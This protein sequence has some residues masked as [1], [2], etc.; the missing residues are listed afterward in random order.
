MKIIYTADSHIYYGDQR[1]A[2]KDLMTA[3]RK[4]HPDVVCNCGDIGE[5][6]IG[7]DMDLVQ[8]LFS[9]QPTLFVP[10]NHDLYSQQKYAPPEAMERFLRNMSYGIPLQKSW[11]DTTTIYEK[12]GVLFLGSILF[13]DFA[14]PRLVMGSKYLDAGCCTID[15]TYINLRGGW[16]QH[17]R[18][19][20]DAFKKKLQLVDESKCKNV[21]IITHYCCFLSQY[22]LNPNEDISAYFYCHQAGEMIKEV[23]NRNADK[24]FYAVGAHGH[25]YNRGEWV[26]DGN[27]FTH[28]IK[29]TYTSQDYISLEIPSITD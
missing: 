15:G 4:E 18:P 6:L 25:E 26:Q 5:I 7:E 2:V 23:A 14:D 12:N 19:L 21:V 27:L 1:K 28:G 3:I 11:T 22:N 8:E 17:T 24:K 20:L 9:I 16:L 10:G 13:A 29:T